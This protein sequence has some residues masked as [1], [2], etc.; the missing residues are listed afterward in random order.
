MKLLLV[1]LLCLL[2]G[3]INAGVRDADQGWVVPPSELSDTECNY[4]IA[5]SVGSLFQIP[6]LP[7]QSLCS[8][9]S[10]RRIALSGR[11]HRLGSEIY[12]EDSL[13][14]ELLYG[15]KLKF[16]LKGNKES[17]QFLSE[18]QWTTF[19]SFVSQFDYKNSLTVKTVIPI[20]G[21]MNPAKDYQQLLMIFKS[22]FVRFSLGVDYT[23]L[24]EKSVRLGLDWLLVKQFS[25]G[26]LVDTGSGSTG[27]TSAVK[28]SRFTIRS[29]HL[30][31]PELGVTHRWQLV[32]LL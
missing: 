18:P 19:Y 22:D 24:G 8:G 12:S 28:Y 17:Q 26:A 13:S 23:E 16:G 4:W 9:W 1:S 7:M 25:A 21:E 20:Y 30:S 32:Y 2:A 6:E 27:F 11:W 15:G 29:S 31:H 3:S 5:T 14:M 10:S